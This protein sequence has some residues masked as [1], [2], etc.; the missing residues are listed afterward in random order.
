MNE[1]PAYAIVEEEPLK[2]VEIK[3]LGQIM[4]IPILGIALSFIVIF[5][6]YFYFKKIKKR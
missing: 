1:I 2:A 3:H 6:E 5:A 4:L